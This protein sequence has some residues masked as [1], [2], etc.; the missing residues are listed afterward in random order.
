MA[1]RYESR[2][3]SSKNKK[4]KPKWLKRL[5]TAAVILIVIGGA[6]YYFG[7]KIASDQLSGYIDKEVEQ[8]GG[9][10]NLRNAANANPEVR[11]FLEEGAQADPSE[12]PFTSKEE[13]TRVVLTK[14]GPGNLQKIQSMAQDGLDAGEQQEVLALAENYLS[15]DEILALKYVANQEINQ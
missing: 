14:V 13:A 4:R 5:M 7:P 15:E 11:Q 6:V 2:M 3:S 10:E 9:Y 12:L 1:S 8:N